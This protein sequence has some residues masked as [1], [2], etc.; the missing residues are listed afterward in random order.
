MQFVEKKRRRE[1]KLELAPLRRRPAH[2]LQCLHLFPRLPGRHL[3]VCRHNCVV[4]SA[5][6][7]NCCDLAAPVSTFA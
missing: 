2:L 7:L 4:K 6:P 1:S 3:G 5:C